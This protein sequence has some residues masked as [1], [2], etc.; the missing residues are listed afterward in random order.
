MG[1]GGVKEVRGILEIIGGNFLEIVGGRKEKVGGR[2][3]C[4]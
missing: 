2:R 4:L 1:R 3:V